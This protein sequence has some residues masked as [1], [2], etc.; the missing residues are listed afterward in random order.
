MVRKLLLPAALGAASVLALLPSAASAHTYLGFS[1]TSGYPVYGS[2]DYTYAPGY[3]SP[4][5]YD[6]QRSAWIAHECWE[7]RERAEEARR[8]YWEHERRQHREWHND[9]DGD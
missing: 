5:Y 9:D 8:R 7:Q 4:G 2:E 3:Y 6:E 1:V